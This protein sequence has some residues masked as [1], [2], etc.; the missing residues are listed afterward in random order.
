MLTAADNIAIARAIAGQPH[1]RDAQFDQILKLLG[2]EELLNHKPRALSGG[3]Q[4]RLAI[5]RALVIRPAIILADEPTG[6]LDRAAGRQLM[7]LIGEINESTGV[8]VLL[9]THDPVFAAYAH[10]V[11]RLVDGALRQDMALVDMQRDPARAFAR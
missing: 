1:E 6:N 10:R 5:A 8:T 11:L 7:D 4:Q 2:L 9:V 3:E